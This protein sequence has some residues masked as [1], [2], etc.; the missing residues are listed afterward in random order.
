MGKVCW[1]G[2]EPLVISGVINTSVHWVIS[3]VTNANV[4]LVSS[5]ARIVQCETKAHFPFL[6]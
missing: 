2:S 6:V 1:E 4:R 5:S 3:G